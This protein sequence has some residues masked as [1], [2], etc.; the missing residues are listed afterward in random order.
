[1]R[2]AV[3]RRDKKAPTTDLQSCIPVFVAR[4][5]RG[6]DPPSRPRNCLTRR[7]EATLAFC[8]RFVLGI[9]MLNA[10]VIFASGLPG[11]RL[12]FFYPGEL[13]KWNVNA[14]PPLL[15]TAC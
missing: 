2:A 9:C 5:V 14:G 11:S 13:S 15:V 8:D 1:M 12:T 4:L 10:L 7:V 3:L 6:R